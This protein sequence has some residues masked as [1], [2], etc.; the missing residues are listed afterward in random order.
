MLRAVILS[1]S[2][3][4]SRGRGGVCVC[5]FVGGQERGEE[6]DYTSDGGDEK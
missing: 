5:V 2:S 3:R 1:E 4:G 6:K